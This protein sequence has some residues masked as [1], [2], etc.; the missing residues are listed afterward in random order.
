MKRKSLTKKPPAIY[1][2]D[3]N[4]QKFLR[5]LSTSEFQNSVVELE[6]MLDSSSES[7]EPAVEKLTELFTRPFNNNKK[8]C[9][10]PKHR[11]AKKKMW[12]D[13]SCFEVS[14]RLKMTAKLLAKSPKCPHLRG[15][16]C[17][18]S[19]EYRKLL[20]WKKKNGKNR[21]YQN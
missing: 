17:K 18:T 3:E 4:K 19:K 2:N 8:V 20:K 21:Q 15:S 11:T 12:Y 13:K 5:S 14:Q 9:K 6:N 7:V 10:K 16:F 1:W